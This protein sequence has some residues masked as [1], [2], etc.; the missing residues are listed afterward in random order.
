MQALGREM[1]SER[2]WFL[3]VRLLEAAAAALLAG[4]AY[5]VWL[6]SVSY[7]GTF[8]ASGEPMA[9]APSLAE[10]IT[11]FTLYGAGSTTTVRLLAAAILVLG[12]LAVLHLVR[13]V[14]NAGLLRWETATVG[15]LASVADLLLLAATA[16]G[17]VRGDPPDPTSGEV[18]SIQQGPTLVEQLLGS[19]ATPVATA[20]V[21]GVATL[22]WVRLPAE[23]QDEVVPAADEDAD[24]SARPARSRRAAGR[25]K[26]ATPPAGDTAAGEEVIVMD[27]IRV[28]GVEQI[29]PVERL[30]PRSE[31]SDD[32]STSSGYDGYLH[33]F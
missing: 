23:L 32:G 33:R 9:D 16:V 27:G 1:S 12:M 14:A 6:F 28:E 21:L 20:L 18:V 10:R 4:S 13:P 5:D 15:A 30:R 22:W 24:P 17:L 7:S 25:A 29:E 3:T 19:V 26:P 31:G 8:D 2:T 11:M